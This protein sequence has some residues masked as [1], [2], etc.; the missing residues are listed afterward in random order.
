[1]EQRLIPSDVSPPEALRTPLLWLRRQRRTDAA[2]DFEAVMASRD[3][4]RIWCDGD[5]PSD[6]FTL[7]ENEADLLGHIGDAEAGSA[8]GFTV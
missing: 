2:A 8:Y 4:L 7:A 5:W 6:D 3:A 1:M